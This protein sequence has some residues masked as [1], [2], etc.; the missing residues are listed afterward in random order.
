MT[1]SGI[2]S[3]NQI[4]KVNR[5]RFQL[6]KKLGQGGTGSVW[7]AK[8]L[9][10]SRG[11]SYAVK[12]MYL[13]ANEMTTASAR[14]EVEN[15]SH[16]SHPSLIKLLDAEANIMVNGR[17]ACVLIMECAPR[18]DLFDFIRINK[19]LR[20]KRGSY[21]DSS[22]VH[23]IFK[24]MVRAL[25]H[26]HKNGICHRDVKP[27]NILFDYNYNA[28]LADMGFSEIFCRDGRMCYLTDQLGSRGYH[29]PEIVM[30]PS[31][32]ENVDV[33]SL[34]VVLFIM[35]AGCPPF[36]QVKRSDWWFDKLAREQYTTF[37]EAHERTQT[38]SSAL[39]KLLQGMLCVDPRRRYSLKD[40]QNSVWFQKQVSM[41]DQ[42]Y[43]HYMHSIYKKK[44]PR[45]TTSTPVPQ[46]CV[47]TKASP[48]SPVVQSK[49][50]T[51]V[52]RNCATSAPPPK[53]P[54]VETKNSKSITSDSDSGSDGGKPE[55]LP[56]ELPTLTGA[57]SVTI[58]STVRYKSK[59]DEDDLE[60]IDSIPR[61][62]SIK[63]TLE[64]LKMD[65][66]LSCKS[67]GL[68]AHNRIDDGDESPLE[69]SRNVS[70]PAARTP[71]LGAEDIN[72]HHYVQH[73]MLGALEDE[74]S[75]EAADS[76]V[77]D[78]DND[79]YFDDDT[80]HQAIRLATKEFE[81]K[82]KSGKSSMRSGGSGE[83]SK[84]K[85]YRRQGSLL[86]RWVPKLLPKLW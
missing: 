84:K 70:I 63:K 58:C 71:I 55:V 48:T 43:R 16:L 64:S 49:L 22:I 36:K 80:I 20:V 59:E 78:D 83:L 75:V 69:I 18:G 45:C 25:D 53:I 21:K 4:L 54:E 14:R 15:M 9:E 10:S 40:I 6:K 44:H 46:E 30:E 3:K 37:W 74:E 85:S 7:L 52:T 65:Q 1:Q 2:L 42:Q 24:D 28:R 26:M 50:K 81:D 60:N 68:P 23:R 17:P 11:S 51:P 29:A 79:V 66:V 27:E 39:K 82:G 77:E 62:A 72:N 13:D 57:N 76:D 31:Y 47:Q 38:F 32:T 33:F 12:I 19:G 8:N 5:R 61:M 56:A 41:S 34:G 67:D 35:Y 73:P 86:S